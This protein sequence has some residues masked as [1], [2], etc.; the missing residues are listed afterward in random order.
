MIVMVDKIGMMRLRIK[1]EKKE[2]EAILKGIREKF[3][4]Y[5][6]IVTGK[7]VNDNCI[8]V[9]GDDKSIEQLSK[10]FVLE[11]WT[12]YVGDRSFYFLKKDDR[13]KAWVDLLGDYD[14]DLKDIIVDNLIC[15][16]V[17]CDN[18]TG[19]FVIEPCCVEG[20]SIDDVRPM[21]KELFTVKDSWIESC[22][23][24]IKLDAIRKIMVRGLI[25]TK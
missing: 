19:H 15:M 4:K 1:R 17:L 8:F 20:K 21:I 2:K 14:K 22:D 10:N 25:G 9:S 6:D 7:I 3:D 11:P 18:I 16:S 24:D 13:L 12:D 23:N 5:T